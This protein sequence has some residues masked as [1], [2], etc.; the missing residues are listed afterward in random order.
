MLKHDLFTSR[1]RRRYRVKA[2]EAAW[3]NGREPRKRTTRKSAYSDLALLLANHCA[4]RITPQT[5]YE[6]AGWLVRVGNPSLRAGPAPDG[7]QWGV[8][9]VV[10]YV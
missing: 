9:T 6:W 3:L 10:E 2:P 8:T 4:G 5:A 1:E 7:T